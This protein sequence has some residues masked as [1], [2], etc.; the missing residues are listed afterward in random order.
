MLLDLTAAE[1]SVLRSALESYLSDLRFEI[2]DTDNR[3][4]RQ[5]LRDERRVLEDIM[6]RVQNIA[7][8]IS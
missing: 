8:S 2:A 4:Y 7:S 3:D 1:F 5:N 6:R